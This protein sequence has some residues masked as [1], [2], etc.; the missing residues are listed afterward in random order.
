MPGMNV[1]YIS[2]EMNKFTTT[3]GVIPKFHL[4]HCYKCEINRAHR[5]II[6][7]VLGSV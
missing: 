6:Y 1:H 7:L 2:V 3:A 5:N 4:Q